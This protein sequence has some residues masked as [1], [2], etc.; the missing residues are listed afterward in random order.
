MSWLTS[1]FETLCIFDLETFKKASLIVKTLYMTTKLNIFHTLP[2]NHRVVLSNY[3][4]YNLCKHKTIIK[5]PT[6]I[7][8]FHDLRDLACSVTR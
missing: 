1:N 5:F 6:A 2:D 8:S 4:N 7:P 3:K